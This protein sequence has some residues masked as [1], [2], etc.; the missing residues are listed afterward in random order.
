MPLLLI[1][2]LAKILLVKPYTATHDISYETNMLDNLPE[3]ALS[4]AQRGNC[5]RSIVETYS[6]CLHAQTSRDS[7]IREVFYIKGGPLY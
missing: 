7:E 2:K 4:L 6:Q 5:A 3:L 1:I